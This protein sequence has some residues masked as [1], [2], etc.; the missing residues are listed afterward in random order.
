MKEINNNVFILKQIKCKF[1]IRTKSVSFKNIKIKIEFASVLFWYKMF[2]GLI[3]L[4]M[5]K[6]VINP[7]YNIYNNESI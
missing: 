6:L 2:V 4:I 7:K 1:N 3:G 5:L